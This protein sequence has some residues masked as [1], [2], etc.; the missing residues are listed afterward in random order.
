MPYVQNEAPLAP[1]M[2][3]REVWLQG[4]DLFS[5]KIIAK[6]NK[7]IHKYLFYTPL[8]SGE[9]FKTVSEHVMMNSLLQSLPQ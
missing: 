6:R 2:F 8:K 7:K 5:L 9:A 4:Q 3:I 1:V